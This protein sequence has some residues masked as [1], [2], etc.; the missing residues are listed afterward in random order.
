MAKKAL[1]K[2]EVEETI[3][4]TTVETTVTLNESAPDKEAPGHATRAYRQ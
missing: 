1:K 2:E 4:E 3:L